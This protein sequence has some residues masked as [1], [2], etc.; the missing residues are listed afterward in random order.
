MISITHMFGDTDTP[1]KKWK[2]IWNVYVCEYMCTKSNYILN[3]HLQHLQTIQVKLYSSYTESM[4]NTVG[5]SN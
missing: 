5:N 4:W 3:K 1:E 2:L